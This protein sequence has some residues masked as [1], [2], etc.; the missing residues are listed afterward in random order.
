MRRPAFCS[1][2]EHTYDETVLCMCWKH[3]MTGA[4]CRRPTSSSQQSTRQQFN[5]NYCKN[6]GWE[7][8]VV[9][10]LCAAHPASDEREKQV[11]PSVNQAYRG[12][13]R[14]FCIVRDHFFLSLSRIFPLWIASIWV[15]A[16]LGALVFGRGE[17]ECTVNL[18]KF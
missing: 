11:I 6:Q 4:K 17:I 13:M 16:F 18:A 15:M 14:R 12:G 10:M 8:G 1:T 7:I 2:P 3:M 9:G 5:K